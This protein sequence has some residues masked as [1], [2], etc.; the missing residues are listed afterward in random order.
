MNTQVSKIELIEMLLKE[1]N[2]ASL[3][4]IKKILQ[5]DLECK[6]EVIKIKKL[7]LKSEQQFHNGEGIDYETILNESE[8][9]YF[10]K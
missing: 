3:L 9:K 5:N 1:N 2:Q 8:S 6:S 10:S 4:S 7:L